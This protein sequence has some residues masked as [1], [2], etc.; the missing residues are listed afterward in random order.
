MDRRLPLR[1][2][3]PGLRRARQGRLRRRC[4][5]GYADPGP[6]RSTLRSGSY[7]DDDSE[8]WTRT[9]RSQPRNL[10]NAS[11]G[12]TWNGS[13]VVGLIPTGGSQVNA[14]RASGSANGYSH[15]PKPVTERLW[16]AVMYAL[17][18]LTAIPHTEVIKPRPAGRFTGCRRPGSTPGPLTA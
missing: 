4:A 5:I 11:H 15:W 12:H 16:G 9:G 14:L 8:E 7:E 6:S 18:G 13:R 10:A 2:K 1:G 17:L 3:S